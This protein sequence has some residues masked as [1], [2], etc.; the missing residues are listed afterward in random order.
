MDLCDDY[1]K[2]IRTWFKRNR[3]AIKATNEQDLWYGFFN[4]QKKQIYPRKRKVLYSKEFYCPPENRKG[5]QLLVKKIESGQDIS[6]YL[7]KISDKPDKFDPLLYDWG[8]YH[9]HLGENKEATSKFIERTGP[10]LFAKVDNNFVYFIQIYRHGRNTKEPPWNKQEMV[11]I[12]HKNWPQS[13]A[14]YRIPG[15]AKLTEKVSDHMHEQ[16]RTH[17]V[18][19]FVEVEEGVVYAPM[20]GGYASSGHSQQ[21]VRWCIRIHNNF[22][23]T[24]L[25]IRNNLL[26][27]FWL[28]ENNTQKK[29][30]HNLNFILV[31]LGRNCFLVIDADSKTPLV[32]INPLGI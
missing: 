4:L 7:N 20:G 15:V 19:T 25:Q 12:I 22:K 3:I 13:I 14:Q 17:G 26:H 21:V 2:M 1:S 5:L 16:M 18:T 11:R 6:P 10:V 8:I 29:I 27:Y 30:D 28:I 32:T 24:E 23:K 9:F 31:D